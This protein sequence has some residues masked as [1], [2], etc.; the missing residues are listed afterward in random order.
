MIDN[1]GKNTK[2]FHTFNMLSLFCILLGNNF[3]IEIDKSTNE[4]TATSRLPT[5]PHI[6]STT[7]NTNAST[8]EKRGQQNRSQRE[9]RQIRM[10]VIV[11]VLMTTFLVCRLPTWIF[12]LYKLYFNATTNLQW[13][14]HYIFGLLSITNCVLNPLLYTFLSQT[15]Q[16]SFGFIEAFR[17]CCKKS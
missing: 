15:V 16:C 3:S 5:T 11:L 2:L 4:S 13:M 1:Q 6:Q 12:L 17:K 10:F 14:L 9:K 7:G 8:N